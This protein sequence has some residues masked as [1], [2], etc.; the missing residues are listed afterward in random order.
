MRTYRFIR[1]T[2]IL[3]LASL[4]MILWLPMLLANAADQHP[5]A[6]TPLQETKQAFTEML[7][8]IHHDALVE[9]VALAQ[10]TWVD[11]IGN[12]LKSYKAT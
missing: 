12:S 4:A 6:G 5:G 2:V 3:A 11:E 7:P 1:L 8:A 9:G 10:G